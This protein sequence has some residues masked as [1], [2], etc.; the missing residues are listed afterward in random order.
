MTERLYDFYIF[1]YQMLRL[2]FGVVY[3]SLFTFLM[4]SLRGN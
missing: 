1:G 4:S 3:I 2:W